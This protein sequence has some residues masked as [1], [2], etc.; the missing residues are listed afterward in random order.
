MPRDP[1][2]KI[3]SFTILHSVL[4]QYT[5]LLLGSRAIER[6]PSKGRI[7]HDLLC[8]KGE[9]AKLEVERGWERKW[10]SDACMARTM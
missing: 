6:F 10:I 3:Y 9:A 7:E 8:G 2:Y 4:Q 1:N 5:Y